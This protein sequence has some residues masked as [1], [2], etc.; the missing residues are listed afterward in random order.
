MGKQPKA[1]RGLAE[2]REQWIELN[3]DEEFELFAQSILSGDFQM[4]L[5]TQDPDRQLQQNNF[6]MLLQLAQARPDEVSLQAVLE[7]SEIPNIQNFLRRN[8]ELMHQKQRDQALRQLDL[9]QIR[10]LMAN[11]GVDEDTAE[12]IIKEG[13]KKAVENYE[14]KQ[15]QGK[16]SAQGTSTIQK[17]AAENSRQSKIEQSNNIRNT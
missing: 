16:E 8:R 5:R 14:Q 11:A 10:K 1:I 7:Q 9:Q 6:A 12:K 13:R 15:K 17:L 2:N 4:K 3:Y